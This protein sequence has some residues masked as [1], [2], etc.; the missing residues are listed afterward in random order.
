MIVKGDLTVF[1]FA[2]RFRDFQ[3][4]TNRL[5]THGLMRAERDQDVERLRDITNVR[6]QRLKQE[7]NR[8][9]ASAVRHNEQDALATIRCLRTGL[10]DDFRDFS[11][12]KPMP[13]GRN[14][15]HSQ[16]FQ[17]HRFRW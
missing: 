8:S 7:S 5:L 16:A 9:G 2:L 6:V 13:C 17:L 15:P 11:R 10:N 4:P 14:F 3:P 1:V 12:R